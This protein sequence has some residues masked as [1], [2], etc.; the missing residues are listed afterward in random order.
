VLR[1]KL[2]E[3]TLLVLPNAWDVASAQLVEAAGLPVV[4]T[5]SAAVA[6]VLGHEDDNTMPP[7]DAFG[8]VARVAA[9]VN[10]P[11]TAD[12]EAGYELDSDEFVRRLLDAGA[13]GCNL[14]DTDHTQGRR[15]GPGALVA[16]EPHAERLGAIKRAARDAGVDIVLNARVDTY[17]RRIGT[18]EEMF[19]ET[20][21]RARLYLDAGADCI[22]PITLGESD[23]IR[24]LV[25]ALAAPLNILV[26]PGSPSLA[27]LTE[28]GVK[29]ASYGSGLF[30]VGLDAVEGFLQDLR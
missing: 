8:A 2:L 20:V 1:T 27:E 19:A 26:R 28:L 22:Y 13:V 18:D 5:S 7:D 14:E 11:I 29:R 17:A 16:A 4:A 12:L 6:R 30:R 25:R 10:V 9:A 21:R 23:V 24:E 15:A 3:D